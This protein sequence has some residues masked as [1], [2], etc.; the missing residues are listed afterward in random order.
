MYFEKGNSVYKDGNKLGKRKEWKYREDRLMNSMI[1]GHR[2][3]MIKDDM[4]MGVDFAK[5]RDLGMVA[6]HRVPRD[7]EYASCIMTPATDD[8]DSIMTE[9]ANREAYA[10]LIRA[11]PACAIA[12]IH[13]DSADLMA[14][15]LLDSMANSP[16]IPPMFI[17]KEEIVEENMFQKFR[18]LMS[19]EMILVKN[20]MSIVA[21]K[22]D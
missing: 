5:G 19:K 22:V 6:Y 10:G 11:F 3:Y 7:R 20:P 16:I 21:V 13:D 9:M 17:P 12:D 2:S 8:L 18:H 14:R 4:I 15:M 1:R